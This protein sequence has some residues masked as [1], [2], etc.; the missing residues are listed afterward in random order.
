MSF[1]L[2]E[3]KR[4]DRIS[5]RTRSR[6]PLLE[7]DQVVDPPSPADSPDRADEASPAE[8]HHRESG[9]EEASNA[10][11]SSEQ[12]SVLLSDGRVEGHSTEEGA[13]T[14]DDKIDVATAD[15]LSGEESKSS[16]HRARVPPPPGARVTSAPET[17]KLDAANASSGAVDNK[18]VEHGSCK[19]PEVDKAADHRPYKLLEDLR[20]E[21]YKLMADMRPR[22]QVSLPRRAGGSEKC[23]SRCTTAWN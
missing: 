8:A 19:R 3:T 21:S 12:E 10:Q 9:V 20:R 2:T 15:R 22:K 18:V 14:N 7:Q 13:L 11:L 5:A 6:R 16:V 4:A 1:L 17:A 23:R